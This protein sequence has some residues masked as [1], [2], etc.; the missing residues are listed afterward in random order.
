SFVQTRYREDAGAIARLLAA[1]PEDK[2]RAAI[3]VLARNQEAMGVVQSL[4]ELEATFNGNV[5]AMYPYVIVNNGDF[6][7]SFMQVV[8][9][10]VAG[11]CFFGKVPQEHWSYPAHVSAEAAA[12]ARAQQAAA[13]VFHGELESYH[14]MCRYFSG[15]F[16]HHPLLR[17]FDYYWRVEPSVHF[18]C[19]LQQDPFLTM[20]ACGEGSKQAAYGWNIVRL[21]LMSTIPSLWSTVFQ[22][23]RDNATLLHPNNGLASVAPGFSRVSVTDL[24]VTEHTVPYTGCH[25]W[26]NFEIG[27]L[28]FFRSE[29]YQ[30]FFAALERSGGFFYERWGDA[31]VHSLAALALLDAR[32]A[33]HFFDDIGYRH[34]DAM[35]CPQA[36]DAVRHCSCMPAVDFNQHQSYC[37]SL[38]RQAG[39]LGQ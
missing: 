21:E 2:P 17:G 11:R 18:Y 10:S 15:F 32:A 28:A 20:Q 26:S 36:P 29:A 4:K 35:H 38:Q 22:F 1:W 19:H 6:S 27:S 8:E 14:F 13:N 3:F 5:S 16:M 30:A 24:R 31:P 33:I 25:Y 23:L 12:K 9:R 34:D 39:L 37:K 7:P